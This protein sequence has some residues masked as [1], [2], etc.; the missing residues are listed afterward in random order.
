MR[1][2]PIAELEDELDR[3]WREAAAPPALAEARQRAG[4]APLTEA[5][6]AP[7]LDGAARQQAVMR[8]CTLNLV[9]AGCGHEQQNLSQVLSEVT[10][11]HPCR[12]ILVLSEDGD[13]DAGGG[14]PRAWASM[15]CHRVAP[16]QPEVCSEQL[17]LAGPATALHEMVT[18]IAGLLVPDMPTFLWWRDRLPTT[19]AERERFGHLA[20]AVDRVLLD[21][22]AF[23]AAGLH[24]AAQLMGAHPGLPFGDLNWA[25]LTRWR[26]AVAHAFDPPAARPLLGRVASARISHSGEG[27]PPAAVRLMAGWLRSRLSPPPAVEFVACG[28]AADSLELQADGQTIRVACPALLSESQALADELRIVGRDSVFEA[29]LTAAVDF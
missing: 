16:G 12:G 2:V 3:L 27:G 7:F 1:I 13:G 28:A 20:G 5:E 19:P 17:V 22:H 24:S 25:R 9:V 23:D 10:G 29:A 15:L 4:H 14:E 18:A 21:S 6:L 11:R 26:A 8:A